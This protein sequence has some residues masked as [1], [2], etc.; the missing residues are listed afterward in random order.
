MPCPRK[1]ESR[2]A[3]QAGEFKHAVTTLVHSHASNPKDGRRYDTHTTCE[4]PEPV[5]IEYLKNGPAYARYGF[6]FPYN[7]RCF[8]K[9]TCAYGANT[10]NKGCVYGPAHK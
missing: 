8:V 1:R 4:V 9:N 3:S 5:D 2:L 10:D 7:P 6:G